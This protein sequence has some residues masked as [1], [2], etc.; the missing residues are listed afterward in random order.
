MQV[1]LQISISE[2]Q[3]YLEA[4]KWLQPNELISAI[5][6]P[7]EGNMNVVLRVV[8]NQGSFILKQSRPYVEKYQ[9]IKAPLERIDTEYQFYKSI[10]GKKIDTHIPTVLAYDAKDHLLQLQ[11]LGECKD[12]TFLYQLR[13]ISPERL[14][15]LTTILFQI[16]STVPSADFPENK[17]LRELNHEHIFTLP[18]LKENGFDLD[19]IQDGLHALSLPYK[20]DTALK[21]IVKSVGI[22]YL[23][24]AK[25]L[26]HGDYYPGSWMKA[27]EHLYVIDPEFSFVGFAE[28]DVGVLIAHIII[29]T[30]ET[31]Y[32][33]II[34][35][36]YQGNLDENLTKKVAGIEIMRR[37]IGLAQLPLERNIPEKDYLLLVAKKMI[38]S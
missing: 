28:F 15:Q 14:K 27:T 7:G 29:A 33:K 36:E 20:Q 8:T 19:H 32:F 24:K 22:Q 4:K 9:Q 12:M 21:A 17:V 6:K 38:F 16:H 3:Q 1:D 2:L 11:D 26:I 23:T 5:E 30:M 18:F 13:K 37:I 10:Q 31:S 35:N 34:L 25:V